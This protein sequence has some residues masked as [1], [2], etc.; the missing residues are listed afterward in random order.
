MKM[1]LNEKKD[2]RRKEDK[3]K[4]NTKKPTKNCL[5]VPSPTLYKLI[6]F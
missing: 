5:L 3:I 6:T 2:E 1:I 4:E